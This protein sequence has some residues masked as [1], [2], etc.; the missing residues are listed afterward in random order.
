MV[1]KTVK[2]KTVKKAVKKPVRKPAK[3]PAK[4]DPRACSECGELHPIRKDLGLSATREEVES[5]ML[6]NNRINAAEQAAQPGALQPGITA[7]QMRIFVTAALEAKAEAMAF[8]RQWW[9]EI[10]DKYN[11]PKDKNVF[12]DF[13]TCEFFLRE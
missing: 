7:E 13:G 11:L 10:T 5:L 8:R 4:K 12:V 6:I 1:K 3:K 2:Q 9:K